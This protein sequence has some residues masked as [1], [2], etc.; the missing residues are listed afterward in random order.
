ML[1]G[2][3][4]EGPEEGPNPEKVGVGGQKGGARRM[5]ARR[6]EAF[7]SPL[8]LPFSLFS[9]WGLLVSFFL[10]LGVFSWNFGG[11]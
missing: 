4:G 9:L 11:V 7:F 2:Q 3:R 8:P 1:W 6:W 10:A 5:G